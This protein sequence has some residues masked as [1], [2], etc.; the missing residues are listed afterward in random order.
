MSPF[1]PPDPLVKVVVIGR[2]TSR[3]KSWTWAQ[4]WDRFDLI[5]LI[6]HS[7]IR[8]FIDYLILEVGKRSFA[9]ISINDI[10]TLG[11]PPIPPVLAPPPPM[12]A[13]IHG[14]RRRKRRKR[15][16]R[17]NGKSRDGDQCGWGC[18]TYKPRKESLNVSGKS[19]LYE[20]KVLLVWEGGSDWLC[21]CCYIMSM[22]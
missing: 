20:L 9:V 19:R 16:V 2:W 18:E 4:T 3:S 1:G 15:V 13:R 14:R 17:W 8:W 5:R 22:V 11:E 7:G 12:V 10:S 21:F 6:V